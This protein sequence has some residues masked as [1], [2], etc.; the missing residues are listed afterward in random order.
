MILCLCHAYMNAKDFMSVSSF[1]N[2]VRR[3]VHSEIFNMDVLI[4]QAYGFNGKKYVS[5]RSFPRRRFI[6]KLIGYNEKWAENYCSNYQFALSIRPLG[7][8]QGQIPLALAKQAPQRLALAEFMPFAYKATKLEL[9]YSS[10]VH[11][12][13]LELFYRHC[14]RSKHTV[15]LIEVLDTGATI[16]MFATETWHNSRNVYGDGE[17]V[18]FRLQP[19]PVSFS[20]NH[21]SIIQSVDDNET[22]SSDAEI[23][24]E[25]L[26]SEFQISTEKFVSMGANAEGGSGLRLN[27]DLTRGSSDKAR[28]FNNEPLVGKDQTVFDVGVVEVYQLVREIDNRPIDVEEKD[29]WKGMFD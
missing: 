18:L 17:C 27:E 26:L 15:T 4:K 24:T 3:V 21:E 22:V 7:F 11:G 16:G 14:A 12:R 8:V 13:S 9:I 20:W 23:R 28:G 1:W 29:I 10:N 2:G 25:A 5:R 6:T 19:D